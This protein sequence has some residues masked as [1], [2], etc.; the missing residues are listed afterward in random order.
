M[1]SVSNA[2]FGCLENYISDVA[3]TVMVGLGYYLFK[4]LKRKSDDFSDP[5]ASLKNLKPKLEKAVQKWQYAKTIE[6]FNELIKSEYNR[7]GIEDP[8]SIIT[9]LNQKGII[10][11]IDTYN[12][13]LLN[14]FEKNNEQY[15][16]MLKEEILDPCGPVTPNNFTLNVLMKG[17]NLKYKN[18]I[19]H[20]NSINPNLNKQELFLNFDRELICLLKTLEDRNI[21]MDLIGQ[22][23]ILDSL[24]D[25]GRLNEAWIQ[26]TNMKK[27]FKPDI[28][29]Y[30][31]ILRGIKKTPE[32]SQD[33]LDR[34]FVILNDAKNTNEIDEQFFNSLLDSCVKFNRV[35]KAETLFNE[36]ESQFTEPTK[37]IEVKKGLTE[38]SYCIM[39][40]GY[41]KIYKLENAEK[42]FNQIKLINEKKAQKLS[43]VTYGAMLNAYTRC[44]NIEKAQELVKEMEANGLEINSYIY[45]TLINGYR[46]SRKYDKA[47]T[48][49][50][51]IMEKSR[52]AELENSKS[53]KNKNDNSEK[54]NTLNKEIKN[55]KKNG[56]DSLNNSQDEIN[57]NNSNDEINLKELSSDNNGNS[58]TIRKIISHNLNIVF[59]NS[60]LDCCVESNKSD[61]ISEILNFL[62]L[63]QNSENFVAKI[64][65]ITYSIIIKGFAK[66]G[67][68]DKVTELYSMLRQREDF[69]LDEML[70]NTIIDSYAKNED[71][72]NSLKIFED[73]KALKIPIS[74]VTYGVLIK[75]Y[76]NLNNNIKAFDI[77]DECVKQEIKPSVVIYQMLLKML[78]KNG[79]I[80]KAVS[81]FKG[82]LKSQ[83]KADAI[84]F[85]SIIKGCLDN[86]RENEAG[87]LILEALN[88][89][90]KVE[91]YLFAN[92]VE[93]LQSENS[94]FKSDKEKKELIP[95]LIEAI[96]TKSRNVEL[97]S[98]NTL[99]KINST[100]KSNNG[101]NESLYFMNEKAVPTNTSIY[102]VAAS[103]SNS[104]S[105][106]ISKSED[107][108][109]TNG[110]YTFSSN[111]G[112][113]DLKG[114][115]KN[116]I[117]VKTEEN[118]NSETSVNNYASHSF[119][120]KQSN[121]NFS[122]NSSNNNNNIISK[123]SIALS[124]DN[125]KTYIPT[126]LRT[127]S[128]PANVVAN[129]TQPA[130]YNFD[131]N[132]NQTNQF[133]NNVHSH[134]S[135]SLYNDRN[136]LYNN[137]NNQKQIKRNFTNNNN[138]NT[139]TNNRGNYTG[140]KSIYG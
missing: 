31:T 113:S 11:N 48:L 129:P 135:N 21:Y 58:K 1:S 26:F 137:I 44:K 59:Y 132:Q 57:L 139:N 62:Q 81:L 117:T 80:D 120:N 67:K 53:G 8:F 64:D 12:A 119:T 61:K 79:N 35:D 68:I 39:I 103:A 60:I 6:E 51:T 70:F 115:Y 124:I 13:L 111:L 76:V 52:I 87:E 65:M 127:V 133:S 49:Y 46:I 131:S 123:K 56:K 85:E 36:Y 136:S 130:K 104:T 66:S 98:L 95:K 38:H 4:G 30:S 74:V 63:N 125:T 22:N 7:E 100:L 15:A 91:N 71:E 47:I 88:D 25:Q 54:E 16:E 41:A 20:S 92:F 72:A 108:P 28:Y 122:T 106:I 93:K 128:T 29:T 14:C 33:W 90:I 24:V 138:F 101:M 99:R 97:Q 94:N 69:K 118:V 112:I 73:M 2:G 5:E 23:T 34:A 19:R 9:I 75:L 17:L 78:I 114:F 55:C 84:I 18:I 3:V 110:N 50:E 82:M 32:L 105:P 107:K 77:F 10:P 45:S 27:K 86:N 83:V 40:K 43:V 126:H 102:A 116:Y 89:G 121:Y 37:E 96:T 134:S 140:E 42:I 109:V